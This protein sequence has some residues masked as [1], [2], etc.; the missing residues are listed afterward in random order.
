[1]GALNCLPAYFE[2]CSQ[3][4]IPRSTITIDNDTLP[5]KARVDQVMHNTR[6][7]IPPIY[8]SEL[9]WVV[10]DRHDDSNAY[11]SLPHS[12]FP[13]IWHS[14]LGPKYLDKDGPARGN[15]ISLA[16]IYA[17]LVVDINLL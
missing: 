13:Q 12:W 5:P 4:F 11:P 9:R 3:D 15:D 7:F 14:P 17:M 8:L 16:S 1:M 10:V 2:C 6:F